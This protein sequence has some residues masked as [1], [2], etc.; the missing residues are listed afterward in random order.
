M[1]LKHIREKKARGGK[2]GETGT[3]TGTVKKIYNARGDDAATGDTEDTENTPRPSTATKYLA[4]KDTKGHEE[5]FS[6]NGETF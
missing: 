6:V 3:E 5:I 4:T 1:K 2:R